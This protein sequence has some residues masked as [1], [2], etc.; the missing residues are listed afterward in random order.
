MLANPHVCSE[1]CRALPSKST[2]T[3]VKSK[4]CAGVLWGEPAWLSQISAR[5]TKSVK[6][7]LI[8]CACSSHLPTTESAERERS[9]NGYRTRLRTRVRPRLGIASSST[10]EVAQ[11]KRSLGTPRSLRRATTTTATGT[12]M[13]AAS[14]SRTTWASRATCKR[15][16][17]SSGCASSTDPRRSTLRR[18]LSKSNGSRRSRPTANARLHAWRSRWVA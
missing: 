6:P 5:G 2:P 18:S 12:A 15:A 13:P 14:P 9:P 7:L 4:V 11:T 3:L 8:K 1:G 10:C 16:T 17:R